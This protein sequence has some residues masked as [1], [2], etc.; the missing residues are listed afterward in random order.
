MHDANAAIAESSG[1]P[2]DDPVDAAAPVPHATR[3]A[4]LTAA[5]GT[6]TSRHRRRA[7]CAFVLNR[8]LPSAVA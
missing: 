5:T 2:S 8:V 7:G 4:R 3:P 1:A 6:R